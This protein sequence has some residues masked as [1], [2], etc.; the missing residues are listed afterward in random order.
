MR[1]KDQRPSHRIDL[2][3]FMVPVAVLQADQKFR[4]MKI[5]EVL[6]ML[7]CNH[8]TVR[9]FLRLFPKTAYELLSDEKMLG[10]SSLYRILLRKTGE[11]G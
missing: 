7:N 5:G 8:E 10:S 9:I 1:K 6:E 3:G 4:E 2:S 11:I